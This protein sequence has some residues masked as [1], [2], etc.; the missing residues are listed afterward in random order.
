MSTNPTQ[1]TSQSP[2]AEDKLENI[3]A[4]ALTII[5]ELHK[6]TEG[7]AKS[8]SALEE[9]QLSKKLEKPPANSRVMVNISSDIDE[10]LESLANK[11]GRT[12]DEILLGGISLIELAVKAKEEGKKFG[13]AEQD[14][15]L[16][17][18]VV[19]L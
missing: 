17:T 3:Q 19:G 16:I 2:T 8:K 18:E 11:I 1:Q 4:M 14:Q 12:K 10:K 7:G 6:L 5:D 15:T 13:V 9:A